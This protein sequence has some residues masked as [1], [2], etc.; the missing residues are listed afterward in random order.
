MFNG[1]LVQQEEH[2]T[3]VHQDQNH[4]VWT[5]VKKKYV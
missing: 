3:R 5:Q 4:A 1:V 2:V